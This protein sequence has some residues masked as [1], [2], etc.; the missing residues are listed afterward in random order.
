MLPFCRC[1]HRKWHLAESFKSVQDESN[2]SEREGHKLGIHICPRFT[3][4]VSKEIQ[5]CIKSQSLGSDA[6]VKQHL[7]DR[8]VW[9][10][11]KVKPL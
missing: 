9:N 3:V 10:D 4:E 8:N 6:R 7:G 11:L 1:H 5:D 2:C